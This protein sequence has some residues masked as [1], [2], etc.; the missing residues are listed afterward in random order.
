MK[1][2]K[3]ASLVSRTHSTAL[4]LA[5]ISTL[6]VTAPQQAS[7]IEFN[8]GDWSG[9]L[10]TTLSYGA[11][12]RIQDRDPRLLGLS[13]IPQ[14]GTAFSVNGDDGNQNYDKGA[15]EQHS[16]SHLRAGTQSQE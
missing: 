15:C 16:Q 14:A 13:G 7:A 12:W 9:N 8:N 2:H 5:V 11:R 3:Q 6:G 4:T 1:A 10:D